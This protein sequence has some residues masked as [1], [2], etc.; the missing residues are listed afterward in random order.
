MRTVLLAAISVMSIFT[1][2]TAFAQEF[3]ADASPGSVFQLPNQPA[4]K[5]Q[6][7]DEDFE[8][9]GDLEIFL[10]RGFHEVD[11]IANNALVAKVYKEVALPD[12]EGR[13][14]KAW[15][16]SWDFGIEIANPTITKQGFKD[17]LVV[18]RAPGDCGDSG[19]LYQIYSLL[20]EVWVKRKEFT[21]LAIVL[22]NVEGNRTEVAAVGND[23]HPSR[24]FVWDG[25]QFLD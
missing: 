6:I 18:S 15:K 2:S 4:Q 7:K 25:Q 16:E 11:Y 14:G 8:F 19:C 1:T 20:G 23:D 10:A 22:K 13:T 17:L 12:Y 5:P 9:D 3:P 21:A 24:V